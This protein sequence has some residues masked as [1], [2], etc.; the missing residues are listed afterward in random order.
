MNKIL[1]RRQR[2][3]GLES[4]AIRALEY[5][6]GNRSLIVDFANGRRYQYGCIER[7]IYR[8]IIKAPSIGKFFNDHIRDRYPYRQL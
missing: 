1:H 7:H 4:S 6:P 5:D 3:D 2:Q 8:T